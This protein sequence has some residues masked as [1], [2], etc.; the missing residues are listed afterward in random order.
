VYNKTQLP[1]KICSL[2][3]T[4][5]QLLETTN[6]YLPKLLTS[7]SLF[8]ELML[9]APPSLSSLEIFTNALSLQTDKTA[10]RPLRNGTELAPGLHSSCSTLIL[11]LHLSLLTSN[12]TCSLLR[13]QPSMSG[14]CNLTPWKSCTPGPMANLRLSLSR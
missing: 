1:S 10:L 5:L 6:R 7:H 12:L 2:A 13:L 8:V 4:L 3:S 9:T 11:S 14:Y